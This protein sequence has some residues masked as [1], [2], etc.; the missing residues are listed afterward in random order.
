MILKLHNFQDKVRILQAARAGEKLLYKQ[1]TIS[2]YKIFRLQSSGKDRHSVQLKNIFAR[3]EW[4][5]GWFTRRSL[6]CSMM[7]PSFLNNW[8]KWRISCLNCLPILLSTGLTHPVPMRL[9]DFKTGS[10]FFKRDLKVLLLSKF[11]FLWKQGMDIYRPLEAS[12]F[13]TG[14][15]GWLFVFFIAL[16]FKASQLILRGQQGDYFL[17]YKT[18]ILAMGA[19]SR[20][21]FYFIVGCKG[22]WSF[23]SC[24]MGL[25]T[26]GSRIWNRPAPGSTFWW[27]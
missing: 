26:R 10:T 20:I 15:W 14:G 27:T 6:E 2:I 24:S 12:T 18:C 23:C 16:Y 4:A 25:C 13:V 11:D 1:H 21:Y 19:V 17:F 5:L 9:N 8:V 22:L 7:M 3:R